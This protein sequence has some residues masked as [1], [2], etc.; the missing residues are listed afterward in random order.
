MAGGG[1]RHRQWSHTQMLGDND[2]KDDHQIVHEKV[3]RGGV[4]LNDKQIP[5]VELTTCDQAGNKWG[6]VLFVVSFSFM[7]VAKGNK[8][9]HNTYFGSNI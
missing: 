9:E 4:S 6:R 1:G 7:S 3:S 2:V 8:S 5:P